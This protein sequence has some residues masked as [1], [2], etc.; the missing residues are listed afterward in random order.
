MELIKSTTTLHLYTQIVLNY[1]FD[2]SAVFG[3]IVWI[4]YSYME[5]F[6][7]SFCSCRMGVV[8]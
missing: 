4:V 8:Y 1:N 6:K 7:I 5:K 3:F 2:I